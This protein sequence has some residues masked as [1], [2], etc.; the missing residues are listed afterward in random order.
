MRIG[1]L[2][3][4]CTTLPYFCHWTSGQLKAMLPHCTFV[5]AAQ[6]T[7]LVSLRSVEPWQYF[8]LKGEVRLTNENG[9]T[10][11]IKAGSVEAGFPLAHLRP[12]QYEVVALEGAKILRVESSKLRAQ[13]KQLDRLRFLLGETSLN[14][15]LDE[16][17]LVDQLVLQASQKTLELP[18][19]PGVAFKVRRLLQ[20][21]NLRTDQIASAIS[22]DPAIVA[23]LIKVANSP[24]YGSQQKCDSVKSAL[25]RLGVERVQQIVMAI[26][27]RDLFHSRQHRLKSLM[28]RRWKHAIEIAAITAVLCKMTPGLSA[29]QGMMVGLLH[30]IGALPIINSAHRF[31]D[32]NEEGGT[33][34]SILTKMVPELSGLI[35]EQWEFGPELIHAARHQNDWFY[36]HDGPADY[37]DALLIAH[38]HH[39]VSSRQ[40]LRLPRI[41]ETP[42]YSKLALG[43]LSPELGI[44]VLH[45]AN[46]QIQDLKYLLS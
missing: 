4:V 22:A 18:A 38:L 12:S 7:V 45:Q 30:E 24:L 33:L 11:Q 14:N 42:A 9:C 23:R 44:Q 41:D 39:L 36:D 31:S 15:D 46:S 19:I 13:Q 17:P 37:T 40:K 29:E 6:E 28:M 5:D 20:Q 26:A 32:L 27:S 1:T 43:D 34:L 10:Q 35:L 8:L 3:R 16:H 21:S 2:Q 25:F